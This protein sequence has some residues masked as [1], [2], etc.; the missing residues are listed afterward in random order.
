MADVVKIDNK[1]SDSAKSESKKTKTKQKAASAKDKSQRRYS[2][3]EVA[4]IIRIGLQHEA[5]S[6][7]NTVDHDELIS[8]GK[9]VGVSDEQIEIAVHLLEQEQQAKDKEG[10]LWLR[11]K[12]HAVVFVGVN[13]LCITINLLTGTD[14]FW[15]GYVL[16][17]MGL[18][19]LG[20][21]AGLRYAPELVEMAMDHTR[22]LAIG[23]HRNAVEDDVNVSFKVSHSSGLIESEGL[24]FIEE[25]RLVIEHQTVDAVF[26][27]FKTGIK[28]TEIPFN[29]ITNVRL[30]PKFWKSELVFHGRSL[31]TFRALPGSSSGILCLKINR[32]SNAAAMNLVEEISRQK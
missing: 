10:L 7:A 11:F 14:T 27:V 13:L 4:D 8:I 23:S 16:L 6:T 2:S 28:K 21:Y 9:E 12:S 5:G 32:Q 25:D 24:L 29:D 30:E 20:H 31:R 26:G 17:G 22:R 19:L 3:D 1:T 15:S 18:F